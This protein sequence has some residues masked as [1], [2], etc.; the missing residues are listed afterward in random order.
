MQHTAVSGER[1]R[2][3]HGFSGRMVPDL[4]GLPRSFWVL[5]GGTLVN[6]VGG[7]VLVFLAI[8]L[9]EARGLTAAQAGTVMAIYGLGAMAGGP[10]GGAVSDRVGRRP[11]LILSLIGGGAS[12]LALGLVTRTVAIV[13]IALLTGILYEMYRPIVSAVV[14]DVVPSEDRPRAYALIYWAV[15]IGASIAPL[16]GGLIAA[17]SYRSLFAVDAA[18]TALYGLIIWAALPE[19]RPAH[20]ASAHTARSAAGAV[21]TDGAFMVFCLLT[22]L[23]SLVFFQSFVSL[24]LDLRAHGISA[25]GFGVLIAVNGVLIVLLQPLAGEMVRGRSRPLTLALASLFLAAGFGMNAWPGSPAWYAGSVTVWTIGEILF[26]PAATTYAADLAPIELRGAYQG[27]FALAF[28]AAFAAAPAA[29][30]YLLTLAGARWLWTACAAAGLTAAGGF[31]LLSRAECAAGRS[32][33]S[34]DR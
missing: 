33:P 4:R 18:T 2:M 11:V 25:A 15:N 1:R 31:A 6:R 17:R 14:A 28:T 13:P 27:A 29:G 12:M 30:G 34:S 23:F 21:L 26:A 5:F 10:L 9:T 8:Y 22:F 16:A 24:P 3:R 20:A 32:S 7:F 19:T